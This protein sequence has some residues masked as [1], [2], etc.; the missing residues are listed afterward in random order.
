MAKVQRVKAKDGSTVEFVEEICGSGGMKDC[1]FSPD[2][3]FVVLFFREEISVQMRERL[4]TIVGTYRERIF[5]REGGDYWK[6]LFCWPT[7]IVEWNGRVGIVSPTYPS[8]FFFQG[9]KF[10][11]KEK[12]GKWFASA[13]LRN[14]FLDDAE[15]GS[16]LSYFHICIKIARAVNRLHAAG[17]SHSDLSYNNVL[18]DPVSERAVVID[19][20]GLVVPGKFPPDVGGTR[21]FIAPEVLETQALKIGDPRKNLPNIKTD[22]HALAVL[23]Y[24]YLLYR[25]PLLGGKVNDRQDSARDDELSL[26]KNALFIEH[27]TDKSNRVDL[28][29]LQPS[30]LP[31]GDP[32][33][34]PYTICGPY[35]K[36]LFDRAFIDG[37]HNPSRRPLASEWE[38]ALVKTTDLMQPCSN[39]K[40]GA[41]WFVFDNKMKPR[42]PFCGTEYRGVLP[43]LNLYSS[44]RKGL[45][46]KPDGHRLM[47]YHHQSLYLW[48]TTNRVVPGAMMKPEDKKPVGDFH[49]HH[50]RWILINRRL[51]SLCDCGDAQS[52]AGTARRRVAPGDYIELTEGRK[53]LFSD[54]DSGRLAVVQLVKN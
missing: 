32:E 1:Y 8:C 48:H 40:C 41:R 11:G 52:P 14:K 46:F 49:F 2:K 7:K 53:I 34:R 24:T 29:Q 44:P 28:R 18:I 35:L 12:V 19:V 37:L 30:E 38:N 39:P 23:I 47:I 21:G 31:Q 10:N 42:C 43:I 15:K 6:E 27:P 50:G 4:E 5:D 54:E 16:W 45:P 20:D 3:S 9:G 17:L 25:H 22:R 36:E 51:P 13:M 26:G 33:K